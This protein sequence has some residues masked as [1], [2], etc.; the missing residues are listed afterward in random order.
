MEGSALYTILQMIA[1]LINNT[2]GTLFQLL[3]L[4]GQL[5]V[6]LGLVAGAAGIGGIL[7]AGAIISIV[8]FFFLKFLW[9]SWKTIIVLAAVGMI[10]IM[11]VFVTLI[12]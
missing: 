5:L 7:L 2:L 8:L 1:V 6:Q 10:L 11:I 9:G 12:F 4:L 3:L